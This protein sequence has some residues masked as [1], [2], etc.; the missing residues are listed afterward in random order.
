MSNALAYSVKSEHRDLKVIK[1]SF[2]IL[3]NAAVSTVYPDQAVFT[4][5]KPSSTTGLYKVTLRNS[6]YGTPQV[7][8]SLSSSTEGSAVAFDAQGGYY[9][10]S[11]GTVEFWTLNSSQAAANV[12]AACVMNFEIVFKDSPASG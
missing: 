3:S 12:N 2:A 11:A 10:S 6:Y 4:V 5:A 8:A 9:N 7:R 1:G